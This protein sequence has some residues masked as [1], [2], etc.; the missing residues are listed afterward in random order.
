MAVYTFLWIHRICA[1]L[2][3]IEELDAYG[4][5][6]PNCIP[7]ISRPKAKV[8]S[9][10][11]EMIPFAILKI[12]VFLLSKTLTW[13]DNPTA[14]GLQKSYVNY[15]RP[16]RASLSAYVRHASRLSFGKPLGVTQIS[17]ISQHLGMSSSGHSALAQQLWPVRVC[18]DKVGWPLIGVVT[19]NTSL[20][21]SLTAKTKFEQFPRKLLEF[22]LGTT[23][24][25]WEL[26]VK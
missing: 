17:Q 6:L 20:G 9:Y 11:S 5:V 10:F 15:G 2:S 7:Y 4:S 21:R 16:I 8:G 12:D 18:S 24:I 13:L 14:R 19:G 23:V 1:I 3:N 25:A 26:S 22:H